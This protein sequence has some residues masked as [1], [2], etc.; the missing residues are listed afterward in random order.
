MQYSKHV[1]WENTFLGRS[2]DIVWRYLIK[3]QNSE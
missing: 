1:I 2:N 3:T